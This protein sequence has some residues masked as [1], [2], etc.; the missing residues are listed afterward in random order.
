MAGK[1]GGAVTPKADFASGL[2]EVLKH[3]LIFIKEFTGFNCKL[4]KYFRWVIFDIVC[5][6][7]ILVLSEFYMRL[8]YLNFI[9]L[10][11]FIRIC[12]YVYFYFILPLSIF[13]K[14][15]KKFIQL[16]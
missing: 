5:K 14:N 3:I 15:Y 16:I 11:I 2:K 4:F 13:L 6:S 7:Y 9:N 8:D 10:S 12:I 1:A